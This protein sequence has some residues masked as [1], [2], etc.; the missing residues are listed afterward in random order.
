[1]EIFIG[2]SL[3]SVITYIFLFMYF[4]IKGKY[5]LNIDIEH[6]CIMLCLI[7]LLVPFCN[8]I[9]FITLIL[10]GLYIL[11]IKGIKVLLCRVL[12]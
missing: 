2:I 10:T 7:G 11:F 9:I 4:K 1:M 8:F 5:F 12:P 6:P 3:I